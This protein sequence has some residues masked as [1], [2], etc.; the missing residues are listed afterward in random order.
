MEGKQNKQK[1]ETKRE[2]QVSSV[3]GQY[4]RRPFKA[5]LKALQ[6]TLPATLARSQGRFHGGVQGSAT[7]P[8]AKN[9]PGKTP[10]C[11]ASRKRPQPR[12]YLRR[13]PVPPSPDPQ[14]RGLRRSGPTGPCPPPVAEPLT[15]GLHAHTPE[16]EAAA[17]E[18]PRGAPNPAA[19]SLYDRGGTRPPRYLSAAALPP[20]GRHYRARPRPP[21]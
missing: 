11:S 6:P 18:P 9:L 4:Y 15:A 2:R 17:S 7:S 13:G 1:K 5:L 14:H 12:G 3:S 16:A 20:P 10:R 19:M 8:A 21:S